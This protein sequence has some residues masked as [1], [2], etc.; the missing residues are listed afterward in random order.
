MYTD[1]E[2]GVYIVRGENIVIMGELVGE[3]RVWFCGG[4]VC[5]LCAVLSG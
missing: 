5:L 3:V 4:V 2:R 1:E